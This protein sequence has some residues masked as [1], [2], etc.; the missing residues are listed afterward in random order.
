METIIM[1]MNVQR[2]PDE[3]IDILPKTR[4]KDMEDE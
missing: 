1:G 2:E 3:I 4:V